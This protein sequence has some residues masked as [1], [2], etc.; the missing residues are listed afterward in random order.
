MCAYSRP[1]VIIMWQ[2]LHDYHMNFWNYQPNFLFL[3]VNSAI[4]LPI[5]YYAINHYDG[6][7][8]YIYI[9]WKIRD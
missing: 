4:P 7:S 5:E 2:K 6:P 9:Y 3:C 1:I 8:N